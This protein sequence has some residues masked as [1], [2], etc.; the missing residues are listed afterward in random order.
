MT[1][2]LPSVIVLEFSSPESNSSILLSSERKM[3]CLD[4]LKKRR[5]DAN[6]KYVNSIHENIAMNLN[7]KNNI[8]G[9]III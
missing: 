2:I 5:I 7:E 1:I 8:H 9:K 4:K 3:S 6:K